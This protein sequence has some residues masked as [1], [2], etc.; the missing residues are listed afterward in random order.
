MVKEGDEHRSLMIMRRYL[1]WCVCSIPPSSNTSSVTLL[2][3][4]EIVSD[5]KAVAE[6]FNNY[7]INI[8]SSLGVKE[9]GSNVLSADDVNDPFELAI[10]KYS[11]H[12]S[13]T[14]ITENFHSSETFEFRP[15]SPEEIMTQVERLDQ[16]KASPMESIPAKVLKENPDLLLPHLIS[17]YNSCIS[18]SYFP[19]ELKAGDI[20]S[21][22]IKDDAFSKKSFR[23]I[24]VL[25]SVSK[26]FER[27][28]V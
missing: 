20:S 8:T 11:L 25:S 1:S 21:L 6:I 24:T 10:I 13:V 2:E 28:H 16:I 18:E 9:T 15:C 22:F 26:I 3:N 12:P 17:T 7:F 19:N 5:Y 27:P 4:G 23:P 14:R